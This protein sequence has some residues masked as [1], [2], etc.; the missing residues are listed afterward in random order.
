MKYTWLSAIQP[1]GVPL[2]FLE[3]LEKR[4]EPFTGE[5][6]RQL[7]AGDAKGWNEVPP[8]PESLEVDL[9]AP[10]A[11]EQEVQEN[12]AVVEAAGPGPKKPQEGEASNKEPLADNPEQ[13]RLSTGNNV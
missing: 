13:E 4:G 11:K 1:G 10:P 6:V 8:V 12:A 7:S 2:E 9:G 3:H 5:D